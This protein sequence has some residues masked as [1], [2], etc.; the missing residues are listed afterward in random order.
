MLVKSTK[1]FD[2]SAEQQSLKEFLND[3]DT[4]GRLDSM[5]IEDDFS[6]PVVLRESEWM[7]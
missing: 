4:D 3:D 6:I 2:E 1:A 7:G 5:L